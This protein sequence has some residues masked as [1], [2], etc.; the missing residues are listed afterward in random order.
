MTSAALPTQELVMAALTKGLLKFLQAS[1][2]AW[3]QCS[4][5]TLS[6]SLSV[7]ENQGIP[8]IVFKSSWPM[9]FNG[10]ELVIKLWGSLG[11][12][13]DESECRSSVLGLKTTKSLQ[14]IHCAHLST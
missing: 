13:C 1:E 6:F 10:D 12:V 14:L 5:Q 4:N 11:K 3:C 8:G 2:I 7:P 9:V